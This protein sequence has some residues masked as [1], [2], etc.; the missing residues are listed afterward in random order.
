MTPREKYELGIIAKAEA[1]QRRIQ[2]RLDRDAA[3]MGWTS[4]D[5]FKT[6]AQSVFPYLNSDY[7]GQ[8]RTKV[9]A[10]NDYLIARQRRLVEES[11]KEAA[12][13]KAKHPHTAVTAAGIFSKKQPF[14]YVDTRDAGLLAG[15][16]AVHNG[17]GHLGNILFGED[18][19]IPTL[20]QA[21]NAGGTT[22]PVTNAG[23]TTTPV[24]N[25][26]GT[27]T[28][29]TN[30][31]GTT[32]PVTNAGGTTTPVT[33]AKSEKSADA[34]VDSSRS[35]TAAS[36]TTVAAKT[37]N[38]TAGT[39]TTG[40]ESTPVSKTAAKKAATE[41][42]KQVPVS[43]APPALQFGALQH[44]IPHGEFTHST[45][46]SNVTIDPIGVYGDNGGSQHAAMQGLYR[47]KNEIP[48]LGSVL[49]FTALLQGK[50]G[51]ASFGDLRKVMHDA[52]AAHAYAN[53][54]NVVDRTKFLIS[55]GR[56]PE[57]ARYE[58]LTEYLL[59]NGQGRAALGVT[60]PEYQ[61]QADASAAR[62]MDIAA[63]VGGDYHANGGFG[64]SPYGVDSFS[65][66]DEYG[67]DITLRGNKI[68]RVP[69]HQLQQGIG[70][71]I[72]GGGAG[73]T[74][75]ADTNLE[76]D[77]K[78]WELEKYLTEAKVDTAKTKAG[79]GSSGGR[80]GRMT[81]EEYAARKEADYEL[82]LRKEMQKEAMKKGAG[83][84]GN[85]TGIDLG[86]PY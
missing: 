68:T 43:T 63:A 3:Q 1:E 17:W 53:Q 60:M 13:F 32:T 78:A 83:A 36:T 75:S 71:L 22:T 76:Y 81:P 74:K 66:N 62:S 29:V 35:H 69:V 5:G 47:D 51:L 79:V 72:N 57:E 58:A 82:W 41:V 45:P 39:K 25:A 27:T 85:T 28:P 42:V 37:G 50:K 4:W 15:V 16:A 38:T 40:G 8:Q 64:Y 48:S 11:E 70:G 86:V 18:A 80:S 61:K 33:S 23:G 46:H 14:T 59:S 31:G 2:T 20:E 65:I 56:T 54:A 49:A 24:T 9:L 30:A 34:S 55:Q 10:E 67:G 19:E 26:G 44:T 7:L 12:D 84:G 6:N 77:K 52:D 21:T 73:S